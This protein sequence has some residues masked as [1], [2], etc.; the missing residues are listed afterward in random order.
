MKRVRG[1]GPVA[2]V[3]P[4]VRSRGRRA[5]RARRLPRARSTSPSSG[6]RGR[7]T[8]AA[9][10]ARPDAQARAPHRSSCSATTSTTGPA[11]DTSPSASTRST[12]PLMP[13]GR[14]STPRSAS[15]TWRAASATPIHPLPAEGH[16]Y[17]GGRPRCDARIPPWPRPVRLRRAPALLLGRASHGTNPLVEV[18]GVDSQHPRA[19]RASCPC[20]RTRRSSSGW[21]RPSARPRALEGGGHA[22]PAAFADH[23]GEQ[24]LL[25]PHRGRRS[26]MRQ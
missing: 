23:G 4:P 8:R 3:L 24:L 25:R 10:S 6:T 21:T 22:P 19:P 16:A 13:R 5:G 11:A 2:A 14:G 9:R 20:A 26:P 15:T 12:P 18:F 7:A 17:A 1:R